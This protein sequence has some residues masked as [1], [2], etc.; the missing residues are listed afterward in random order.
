MSQ[1]HTPAEIDAMFSRL[2]AES[3]AQAQRA[4]T[5][6]QTARPA[7]ARPPV[8]GSREARQAATS[9]L[10]ALIA[11][12]RKAIHSLNDGILPGG[13]EI[14]CLAVQVGHYTCTSCG[15]ETEALNLPTIFL[16]Y[17]QTRHKE[18]KFMRPVREGEFD[19]YHYIC[20]VP[21]Q[22]ERTTSQVPVC[23]HCLHIPP[24]REVPLVIL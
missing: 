14:E 10:D 19:F 7:A 22:V 16:V 11:S 13:W 6:R 5:P 24:V 1:A 17:H 4:R 3:A 15:T 23:Q 20:N 9:R 8:P 21:L 18:T 2:L 12:R